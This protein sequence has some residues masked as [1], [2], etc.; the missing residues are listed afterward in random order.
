MHDLRLSA[1]ERRLLLHSLTWDHSIRVRVEL[2]ENNP[3]EAFYQRLGGK[4]CEV[5][6]LQIG[7]QDYNEI[8]YGWESL[9]DLGR[10]PRR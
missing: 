3:A 5:K 9:D 4:R 7:G 6:V 10:G 2:L 1:R 8:A